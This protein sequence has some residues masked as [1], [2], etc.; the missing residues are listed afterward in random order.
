MNAATIIQPVA[1]GDDRRPFGPRSLMCSALN[2]NRLKP[3]IGRRQATPVQKCHDCAG[4]DRVPLFC[5]SGGLAG[6]HGLF[7]GDDLETAH[8]MV[9]VLP[10]STRD[11]RRGRAV[12]A[13]VAAGMVS[14]NW[15]ARR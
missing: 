9:V 12:C 15:A 14:S 5:A 4:N 2:R 13:R 6:L 8:P 3:I 1:T 11:L 7:C 10:H